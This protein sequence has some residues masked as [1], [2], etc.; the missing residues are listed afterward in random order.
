MGGN[1]TIGLASNTTFMGEGY[2]EDHQQKRG[3]KGA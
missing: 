3:K 1:A 2:Y